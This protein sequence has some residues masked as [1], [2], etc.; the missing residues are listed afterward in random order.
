MDKA[1][2]YK[3]YIK[4]ILRDYAPYQQKHDEFETQIIM[5]DENGHYY[6][7]RIGWA[8]YRR[9]HACL[10]HI[11]LKGEKIWIQRDG[12][13]YGVATELMD[14]GVPKEDIVLAFHAPYKR[15]FTGFATA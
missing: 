10:I 7:M 6:L 4:K 3:G 14:L 2:K 1:A 11:D 13:E 5:D 9:I 12:T 8:G 15:P